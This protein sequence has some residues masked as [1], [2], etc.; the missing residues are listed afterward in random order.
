MSLRAAYGTF[1]DNHL[2]SLPGVTDIVD[3]SARLSGRSSRGFPQPVL[4][5]MHL[6][7]SCRKA[8]QVRFRA[9]HQRRT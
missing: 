3:G 2:T 5:G 8:R 7:A 9:D 1:Y 4:P 6:A